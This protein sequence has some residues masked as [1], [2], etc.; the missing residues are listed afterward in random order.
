MFLLVILIIVLALLNA[1]M[2]S[3][4]DVHCM[5]SSM[6]SVNDPMALRELDHHA[7]PVFAF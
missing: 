3:E 4:T 5:Q 1:I 6:L 7:L 2:S